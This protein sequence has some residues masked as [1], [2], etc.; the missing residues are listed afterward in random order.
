MATLSGRPHDDARIYAVLGPT[1]TGK[2]Y[3]AIERMLGHRSGMIGFPLRLLARE[4]YDRIARLKGAAN[5]ALITGEERIV[6]PAP[7]WYVCTVEAMPLDREVA[8]LAVDEIQMAADRERGHVFTDRLLRARGYAETMFLGSDTAKPIIR[9][10]V[11]TAEFIVRPRLSKL[12]YAGPQKIT[13]L[14]RRSAIVAFSA[15]DVYGIAELVRRQRG[16]AAV[17][18]GALSPRTRNAQVAMY[19]AGEVDYLIATDAIGM[20]L[21]MDIDHVAFAELVKFD[22]RSPRRLSNAELAQIAGRAGRHMRDGTFG[23][24]HEIGGLDAATVEAIENHR[25]PPL[26]GVYW[27]NPDLDFRSPT[28]LLASLERRPPMPELIRMREADDHMTLAALVRDPGILDLARDPAGVRL[29][30]ETCQIPDF[31]KTM[32]DAHPR[33]V[34][35]IF[36]RLRTYGRLPTDWIANQVARLDRVEGDI[37]ALLT[38]L[39]HIRTWTYVAHRPGWLDDAAAWQE[40]TR[41]I[42]DR[43]SD[44]LHERLTQRFVDR[45]AAVLMRRLN[46]GAELLSAVTKDGEV[47]VEGQF[48]GRLEG[49]N[50]VADAT[51]KDGARAL[52]SAANRAVRRDIADRVRRFA[53]APDDAFSLDPQGRIHWQGQPV[54]RLVAGDDALTPRVEPLRADLLEA[55]HREVVRRRLAAWVDAYLQARLEALYRL[56]GIEASGP[57]RGI[58][59]ELATALGTV[60]RGRVA[61]LLAALG[62]ADRTAL[63]RAGVHIGDIAVF[64]PGLRGAASVELRAL[65]WA[66]HAGKPV[67]APFGVPL[68]LP[69]QPDL[70]PGLMAACGYLAAGRLYVR[71]DRLERLGELARRRAVQ[72][73]FALTPEFGAL[74]GA[75]QRDVPGVL[76]A[77]GYRA[78]READGAG[79]LL[80]VRPVKRRGG[81]RKK[82]RPHA[83]SP[84][85]ELRRLIGS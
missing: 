1:N 21:N 56:R 17:V 65:L 47:L 44:A 31:R 9:R 66:V 3:L 27:R 57:A 18:F 82:P 68:S 48:A 13:R 14:P 70:P 24:T 42:E 43:L 69:R 45:R 59:F 83:H 80:A 39:A 6:P 33:L 61:P 54:A 62:D 26:T 76:A 41:A 34:G 81:R 20:G 52:L 71:A 7:R 12:S 49:F 75:R 72:G 8:F 22:G 53:E 28:A 32:G 2:T 16:G 60:P 15:A 23:T 78:T 35:Q 5:V 4:N 29:L 25:F 30:W 51:A 38:R 37:D 11:P 63:R 50:F 19:Q 36:R 77:L 73:A 79:T 40:R 46:D 74:I 85:A 67:P 84:F 58:A 55:Q 10:L 64:M